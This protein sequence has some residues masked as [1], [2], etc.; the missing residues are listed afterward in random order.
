MTSS[1]TEASTIGGYFGLEMPKAGGEYHK[2][3]LALNFG[4]N[5]LELVLK[6]LGCRKLYLPHY[7]CDAVLDIVEKMRIEPIFYCINDCLNPLHEEIIDADT[8]VL[9]VN[10]FGL[11]EVSSIELARMASHPVIIDNTQAF[12][13]R[14]V[15]GTISFNSARK[16]F[17]VPDGSYLYAAKIP[18]EA[19]KRDVSYQ[20]CEHLLRAVDQGTRA[21]YKSFLEIEDSLKAAPILGMS[22]LSR[23]LL[24][25][26]DYD[27]AANCRRTNYMW[28]DA[29]LKHLN[30]LHLPLSGLQVPLCYPL[31]VNNGEQLKMQLIRNGVFVPTFWRGVIERAPK[32]GMEVRLAT[33]LVCLPIDQRYGLDT[34]EEIFNQVKRWH[35]P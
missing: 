29:K 23:C 13:E 17:G 19:L 15:P 24:S 35:K 1:R 31:L 12:Y 34:M 21:G 16:Y 20:R 26:I 18:F 14:Q 33:D 3:A 4:R 2:D 27:Y 6:Y 9:Y 22:N 8:A 7:I 28:I 5:A 11:K 32:N 25:G 30:K 10:Y